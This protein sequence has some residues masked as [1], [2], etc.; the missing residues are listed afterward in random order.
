MKNK[1]QDVP[2]CYQQNFNFDN[3]L[4]RD[5]KHQQSY[6]DKTDML[7]FTKASQLINVALMP[8]SVVMYCFRYQ[9]TIKKNRYNTIKKNINVL[10]LHRTLGKT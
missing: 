3:C 2:L 5:I 9:T 1:L 7:T 10:F 4:K 8:L 6:F